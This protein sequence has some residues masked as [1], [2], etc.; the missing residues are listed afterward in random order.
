MATETM[1]RRGNDSGMEYVNNGAHEG[2]RRR[3][4]QP[5]G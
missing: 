5:Q 2:G 1:I 4:R 3:K